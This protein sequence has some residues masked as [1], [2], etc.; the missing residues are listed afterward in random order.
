MSKSDNFVETIRT[1]SVACDIRHKDGGGSG[2]SLPDCVRGMVF[3][4]AAVLS[5]HFFDP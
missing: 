4:S 5:D 3:A 1:H 2:G